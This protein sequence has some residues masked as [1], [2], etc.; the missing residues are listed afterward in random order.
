VSP[1]PFEHQAINTRQQIVLAL[2]K[3]FGW[4]SILA[5]TPGKKFVALGYPH[6]SNWDFIPAV[7]WAWST[8]LKMNFIGKAALF[9]GIMGP[10]MKR[11][12]GIP[13][14]RDKSKNFVD[15]IV[16]IIKTRD[17]IALI[18]AAEGTRKK[19][20][21][22]RSGF[23]Y[24]ALE[25]NVPIGLAYMDWKRREIGIKQYLMPSGDLEKDFE[26]IKAYY[27][28]VTGRDPS[29]QSPIALKPKDS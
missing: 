22:W 11:L 1:I 9:K 16:E 10:I 5:P 6:T 24:M 27:Q 15:Q 25:A 18:I 2:M 8:G 28:D 29:K 4:K 13:L 3:L 17:E 19:A 23:Y 20:E 26:I 21:Y 12:G 7:A 14:E